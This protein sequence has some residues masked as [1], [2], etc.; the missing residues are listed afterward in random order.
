ME[1]ANGRPEIGQIV[2]IVR[3]RDQGKYAV[4]IGY[5]GD[6]FALIADGKKRKFDNP[7]KKNFIHLEPQDEISS[8]VVNS[9]SESGRVTNAKLRYAIQRY[10]EKI[11][12]DTQTRK[13]E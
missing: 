5:E 1:G 13:G 6:R 3:G 10:T 8:E 11:Q 12:S 4:V 2:K 7:K 9:L